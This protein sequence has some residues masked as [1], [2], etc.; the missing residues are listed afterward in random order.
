MSNLA[1]T[2]Q[3][4]LTAVKAHPG[5][6]TAQEAHVDV[7]QKPAIGMCLFPASN[8]NAVTACRLYNRVV[9]RDVPYPAIARRASE[10]VALAAVNPPTA[11][12]ATGNTLILIVPLYPAVVTEKQTECC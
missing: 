8:S 6:A 1:A 11:A 4:Y 5:R 9:P 10:K 12:A 7:S 3:S 2:K